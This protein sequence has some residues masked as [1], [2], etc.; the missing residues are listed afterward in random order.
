MQSLNTHP[1]EYHHE[2]IVN[3][4]SHNSTKYLYNIGIRMIND[5]NVL[6]LRD[7]EIHD[8]SMDDLAKEVSFPCENPTLHFGFNASVTCVRTFVTGCA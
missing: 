6:L 1:S 5:V 4:R 2:K 8:P 7:N 3:E